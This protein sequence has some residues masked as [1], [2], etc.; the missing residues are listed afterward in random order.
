MLGLLERILHALVHA[1][2]ESDKFVSS[3]LHILFSSLTDAWFW[4]AGANSLHLLFLGLTDAW[5]WTVGAKKGGKSVS[6]RR[7]SF[8]TQ[9]SIMNVDSK[10]KW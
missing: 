6:T 1:P 9:F 4:T 7:F 5:L 8:D 3:S 2:Q 10:R